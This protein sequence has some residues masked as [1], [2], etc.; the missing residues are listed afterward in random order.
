MGLMKNANQVRNTETAKTVK[1]ERNF[2]LPPI[3]RAQG[4]DYNDVP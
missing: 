3:A 2:K 1:Q 4:N